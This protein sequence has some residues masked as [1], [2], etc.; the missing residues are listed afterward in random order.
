MVELEAIQQAIG[1]RMGEEFERAYDRILA[2]ITSHNQPPL[3]ST[4][5]HSP[6]LETRD[7]SPTASVQPSKIRKSQKNSD[8]KK[9]SE[10]H[11]RKAS[12]QQSVESGKS[13]GK[14][15]LETLSKPFHRR[16]SSE[17]VVPVRTSFH[18]G[19]GSRMPSISEQRPV[20]LVYEQE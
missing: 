7:H 9:S 15:T 1:N 14:K 17:G 8:M 10:Q 20:A 4:T 6:L 11:S 2:A 13:L 19:G 18:L 5:D 12:W 16:R 3:P